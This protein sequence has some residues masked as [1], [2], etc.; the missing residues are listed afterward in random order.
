MKKWFLIAALLLPSLVMAQTAPTLYWEH[1][2]A[3]VT[4]FDCAIDGG[5]AVS[6]GLPTP[7][8]TTYSSALSN[9]GTMAAGSH[10]LV[11]RA[12]NSAGCTAG[13]TIY[14]VKL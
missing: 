4:Y 9:C 10:T 3:D 11:I 8:G 5:T 7:S 1:D 6:L 13:R 2:G 14:V 12:C